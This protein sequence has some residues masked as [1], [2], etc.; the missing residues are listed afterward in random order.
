MKRSMPRLLLAL[1]LA[2]CVAAAQD[3]DEAREEWVLQGRDDAETRFSPLDQIDASNVAKLGLVWSLAKAD[4]LPL[5]QGGVLYGTIEGAVY[6]ADAKTGLVQWRWE[7]ASRTSG[8]ALHEGRV[9]A[10]LADGRVIALD[11][12]TGKAV[13]TAEDRQRPAL[14]VRIVKDKLMVRS[15]RRI[16]AYDAAAGAG[17]W[18]VEAVADTGAMAYDAEI[19]VLYAGSIAVK[20]DT[21]N[22]VWQ[23]GRGLRAV[24]ADVTI[25]GR[26]RK[27][28]VQ[29]GDGGVLRVTDRITGEP[30]HERKAATRDGAASLHAGILYVPVDDGLAAID[31]AKDAETWRSTFSGGGSGGAAMATAGGLVFF[32]NA[33]YEA[34]TGTR[35]W[36]EPRLRD[37]G[38]NMSYMLGGRQYVA[39]LA[40]GR[41][42]AFALDGEAAWPSD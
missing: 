19:D 11:A 3:P 29:S 14:E 40:Q 35:A 5:M 27:T 17:L 38:A 16:T 10:G 26:V 1:A 7:A 41:L 8:V 22:W 15:S 39:M 42:Y 25:D 36:R 28:I 32:G 9:Y 21:G 37:V 4:S 30:I 31:V 33:A 13:W 23:T 2:V 6:A 34:A 20:P 24:L 12:A 18:W